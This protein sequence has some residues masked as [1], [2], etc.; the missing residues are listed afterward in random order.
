[1]RFIPWQTLVFAAA[2]A[3]AACA[4]DDDDLRV[5]SDDIL[6]DTAT[7]GARF[8]A[9]GAL[10]VV[11]AHGRTTPFCTAT[12][13]APTQVLTSQRCAERHSPSKVAFLVGARARQPKQI[14]R[15]RGVAAE[16]SVGGDRG[17]VQGVGAD[18]AIVHLSAPV[19]GVTPLPVAP[20][21]ASLVGRR[22]DV[23]GYGVRDDHG[24]RDERRRGSMELVGVGGRHYGQRLLDGVEA[25]LG[26]DHDDAD[27]CHGDEGGP[28]LRTVDGALTVFGVASW[29]PRGCYGGAIYAIVSD[30][31]VDL[32]ARETACPLIPAA[33]TCD[34]DVAIRCSAPGEGPLRPLSTDCSTLLQTCG[35]DDA[36][37][38]AC[39]DP[40]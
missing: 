25:W 8:D 5:D 23:V 13:I 39:V 11:D 35:F 27:L 20:L 36:G 1:M 10:A 4:V 3:G 21:G 31:V 2:A 38:V 37:A 18:V 30:A 16:E 9:I 40:A 28:A 34:G 7:T 17:G 26:G 6:G 22:F 24:R 29:F 14:I 32:I 12:L 19:T 15:A 33:G